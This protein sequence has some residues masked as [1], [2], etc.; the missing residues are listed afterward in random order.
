V[1]DAADPNVGLVRI[2]LAG[3]MKSA[4]TYAC[5]VL[6]RYFDVVPFTYPAVDFEAEHNLTPWFYLPLRGKPFCFNLH[7]LPYASNLQIA[8][9]ERISLVGG[10]R[11]VADM[12]VS[13]DDHAMT[14]DENGPGLFLVDHAKYR[15]LAPRE[16][17]AFLLDALLPWYLGFYLR[18]RKAGLPLHG[19]EQLVADPRAYF[20]DA[21]AWLLDGPPDEQRLTASLAPTPGAQDRF[22]VGRVGRAAERFDEEMR[23]ALEDR[24]LRHPERAQLEILLWELPWAVPR[25]EPRGALDGD[26]VRREDD[27]ALYFVSRGRAYSVP[28]RDWLASRS[29]ERRAP[30]TVSA[31]ALA[32]CE[33]GEALR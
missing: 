29:G 19:Y 7:M 22:N 5:S 10:W 3:P 30:R 21:L 6:G 1:T 2:V 23:R 17:Y 9:Q 16:R 13:Y 24:I 18:W 12:L 31:A 33:V 15:A 14:L 32:A 20:T 4:S 28:A 8:T 26:V 27:G 25:L 11:N